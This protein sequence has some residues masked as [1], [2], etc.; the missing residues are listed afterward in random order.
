M[1][2]INEKRL[3]IMLLF[4]KLSYYCTLTLSPS[5]CWHLLVGSYPTYIKP[6]VFFSAV[7]YSSQDNQL[8]VIECNLRVSRS[9]PFVSKTL[10]V[11]FIAMATRLIIGERIEPLGELIGNGRVG[12]KVS[13]WFAGACMEKTHGIWE[14]HSREIWAFRGKYLQFW[15]EIYHLD[16]YFGLFLTTNS[17]NV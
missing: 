6:F 13:H 5:R 17:E 11:N 2:R 16:G 14:S 15:G 7:R 3:Q 8:K 4:L 10:G 9:F 12:V 1:F